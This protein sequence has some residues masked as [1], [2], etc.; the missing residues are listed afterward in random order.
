FTVIGAALE[1]NSR[2]PASSMEFI[3]LNPQLL[4]KTLLRRYYTR[5]RMINAEAKAQFVA[6]DLEPLPEV[7]SARPSLAPKLGKAEGG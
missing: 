6:P 7:T 1:V 2:T 3:R 4:D 5:E